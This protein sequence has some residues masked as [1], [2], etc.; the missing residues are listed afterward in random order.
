MDEFEEEVEEDIDD[1]LD[2][3]P[4]EVQLGM[5]EQAVEKAAIHLATEAVM[6]PKLLAAINS[7]S[8]K[9]EEQLRMIALI[10]RYQEVVAA[11]LST[12]SADGVNA[13]LERYR[14]ASDQTFE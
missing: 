10:D 12:C 9:P 13:I 5:A 6:L 1:E 8:L 7:E 2:R 11:A 4:I 14:G 3:T